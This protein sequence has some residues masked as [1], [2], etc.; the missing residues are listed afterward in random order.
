MMWLPPFMETTYDQEVEAIKKEKTMPFIPTHEEMSLNKGLR[1]GIKACLD[2]KYGEEGLR[3]MPEV[4]N[5]LG[6]QQYEQL[7][8]IVKKSKTLDEVR[9]SI[10]TLIDE[11][12][13]DPYDYG[14]E[15][16]P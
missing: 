11:A 4:E 5:S 8:E 3:L 14:D 1:A 7:L 9:Q 15:S 12:N 16:A 6:W 10:P 2:I 13:R